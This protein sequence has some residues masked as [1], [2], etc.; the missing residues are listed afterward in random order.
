MAF[1][2]IDEIKSRLDV[3][4]VIGGYVK[5]Q[6]A[7]VNFR[8]P[9]PFHSEKTPS[10]FVSPARQSW[11]C[12]GACSEGGDIFKFVMKI[13]SV[14]F[15]DA[16]RILAKKAGVELKRQDPKLAT[17]KQRLCEIAELACKFFEKQLE[18]SREGKE[19]K[20]YL[21]GRGIKEE[22]IKKWRLGYS[23][24]LWAGLSDFLVSR[25]Y[26]REE[27]EKA[28]LCLKSEKSSNYYDRFRGRIMFPVFDFGS[29]VVGFGGRVFKHDS[30]PDGQKE[31]KYINTPN[32]LIYDKS[33]IL[34]GLQ[35]AGT[36]I[37]KKNFAVLVEGYVDAIMAQ[38]AGFENTVASSGTALTPWQL[39]IL[40]RHSENLFTAFD[41][42]PAGDTAT[43]RSIGFAQEMGFNIK[44]VV[45]PGD[46]DPADAVLKD[47]KIWQDS[48]ER[49]RTI[50]DFYFENT[51]AKFDKNFLEGKKEI[52][53]ILIPIIKKIPNKIE[54]SLWVKDLAERIG[55]REE[56]VLEELE[57]IEIAGQEPYFQEATEP[58]VEE[59]ASSPLVVN[60]RQGLM[61]ERLVILALRAPKNLDIIQDSDFGFLTPHIVDMISFLRQKEK[62][63]DVLVQNFSS[64][65]AKR[66]EYLSI[67][68]EAEIALATPEDP[69]KKKMDWMK[70]S[71]AEEI[72]EE[73]RACLREIKTVAFKNKLD[74]ISQKI[75]EAE[76]GKNPEMVLRLMKEFNDFSKQKTDL[77]I[78]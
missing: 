50:H 72:E 35:T 64:D 5:L 18:G 47:P 55:T 19:V 14:E 60:T 40:K 38:Q 48:V 36:E 56:N 23:P 78:I 9:C 59:I 26:K 8:A 49:A 11:H 13:E 46:M 37:R 68:S 25:G 10:F 17:E 70:K 1:S 27:I 45:M 73:F 43:K 15:G 62:G 3:A 7:G 63:K 75:K 52:S 77:E 12:F 76:V 30:R 57:K 71:E 66:L 4:E 41:M 34:Y 61:E 51:F 33:R 44:V 74:E 20:N 29:Q 67:K 53:K 16:L 22:T 32:T 58:A 24:D 65:L 39:K 54:Q 31:A 2:P 21:L 6:K 28:G 69:A 42:D